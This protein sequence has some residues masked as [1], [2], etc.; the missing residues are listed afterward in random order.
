M[1]PI[2]DVINEANSSLLNLLKFKNNGNNIDMIVIY[3]VSPVI[4][5]II[6]VYLKCPRSLTIVKE[7][8]E[9]CLSQKTR[10]IDTLL[11]YILS[12]YAGNLIVNRAIELLDDAKSRNVTIGN[13]YGSVFHFA[14]P[15]VLSSCRARHSFPETY[16]YF[17]PAY[18]KYKSYPHNSFL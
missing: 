15:M 2:R 9:N 14:R 4:F 11:S 13:C 16:I 17:S 8:S 12:Y 1:D 5:D 6:W 18:W 7:I 3:R 10:T